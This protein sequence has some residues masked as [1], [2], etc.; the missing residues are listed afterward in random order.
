RM[1]ERARAM[2]SDAA[3]IYARADLERLDLRAAS[4]DLAHSSL[5]LHYIN[6][7]AGLLAIVHRA[8]VPGAHLI[9]SVEHPIY[10]APMHPGWSV[11]AAGCK[12]WPV[13]GYQVEGPRTTDWLVK[14]VIKQ[15]RTIGTY[16]NLLIRLGFAIS[17]VEEWSPTDDEIATRPELAEERE[18]PMLLPVAARR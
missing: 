6:D 10:T 15:H 13:D 1:L 11:D 4:F 18:R 8:L 5:A 9:F 3:I 16:L 7:L 2:T 14:G 12:T 17:H